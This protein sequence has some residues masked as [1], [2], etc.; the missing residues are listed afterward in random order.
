MAPTVLPDTCSTFAH[1]RLEVDQLR[2]PLPH[3]GTARGSGVWQGAGG[4]ARSI[5]GGAPGGEL[6][7]RAS[8]LDVL[9]GSVG[10]AIGR[11]VLGRRLRAHRCAR[12]VRIF[13]YVGSPYF[14]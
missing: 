11:V 1:D 8:V 12:W 4:S 13:L 3:Q 2:P 9:G 10:R 7:L 5:R 6:A 14:S